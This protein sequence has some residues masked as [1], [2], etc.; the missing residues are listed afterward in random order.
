MFN[1]ITLIV[2]DFLIVCDINFNCNA[3]MM[4]IY[5]I[6]SHA[7]SLRRGKKEP[8]FLQ[9]SSRLHTFIETLFDSQ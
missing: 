2:S 7:A 3:L 5:Y 6:Q 8:S 1:I 9:K 4:N